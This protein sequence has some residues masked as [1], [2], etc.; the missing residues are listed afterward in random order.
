MLIAAI[1][2]I[3]IKKISIFIYQEKWRDWRDKWIK[4]IGDNIVHVV[5]ILTGWSNNDIGSQRIKKI[6]WKT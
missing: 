1:Y 5:G 4:D 3:I 6:V 2:A